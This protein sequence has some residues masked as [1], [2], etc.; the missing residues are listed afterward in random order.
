MDWAGPTGVALKALAQNWGSLQ[1]RAAEAFANWGESTVSS[2]VAA[3]KA[4]SKKTEI[5]ASGGVRSGLDA[6][7]LIALGAKRIGYAKPALEAA[8]KGEAPLHR[9]MEQQ[10]FEL[11]VALFCTGSVSPETLRKRKCVRERPSIPFQEK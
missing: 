6:A 1:A 11:K 2:V 3:E 7:K 4:L 9:W 8:L 10:E 5:W